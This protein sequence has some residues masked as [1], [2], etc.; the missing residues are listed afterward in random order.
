MI[1]LRQSLNDFTR[2]F[3]HKDSLNNNNLMNFL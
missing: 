3:K 2:L 1:V